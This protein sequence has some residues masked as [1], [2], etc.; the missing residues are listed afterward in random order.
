MGGGG[1]P[2]DASTSLAGL[3]LTA[4]IWREGGG[5][6]GMQPNAMNRRTSFVQPVHSLFQSIKSPPVFQVYGHR[7]GC[8]FC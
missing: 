3:W 4:A 8:L 7:N 5:E 6:S 2:V 1:N